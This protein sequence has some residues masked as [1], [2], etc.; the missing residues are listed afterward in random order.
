MRKDYS[1][2]TLHALAIN[3]DPGSLPIARCSKVAFP[4]NPLDTATDRQACRRKEAPPASGAMIARRAEGRSD[5]PQST[6]AG[7]GGSP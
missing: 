2:C 7:T 4:W 1:C 5:D 6:R 3:V